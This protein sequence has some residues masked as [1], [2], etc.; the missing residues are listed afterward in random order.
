MT[1]TYNTPQKIYRPVQSYRPAN[2]PVSRTREQFAARFANGA[3]MQEI[4]REKAAKKALE[5]K[6]E[7]EEKQ[8]ARLKEDLDAKASKGIEWGGS[9]L[10]EEKGSNVPIKSELGRLRR[11]LDR[12]ETL[13]PSERDLLG[14][15]DIPEAKDLLKINRERID[16]SE[17]KGFT[18]SPIQLLMRSIED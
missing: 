15:S 16:R 2:F 14:K 5:L 13:S 10:E 11:A 3:S 8:A 7:V 17:M 18:L 9:E 6:K 4:L 12:G 1:L